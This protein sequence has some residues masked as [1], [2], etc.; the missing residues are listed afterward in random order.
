MVVQIWLMGHNAPTPDLVHFISLSVRKLRPELI[1]DWLSSLSEQMAGQSLILESE[2]QTSV[3][4]TKP[5]VTVGSVEV[6]F[7]CIRSI[8]LCIKDFI[9]PAA[10]AAHTV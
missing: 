8:N 4:I 3:C 9:P 7:L 1:S 6:P 5:L 2:S 10:P